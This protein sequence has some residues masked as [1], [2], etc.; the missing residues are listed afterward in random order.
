MKSPSLSLVLAPAK[1][2]S[3]RTFAP[4][5]HTKLGLVTWEDPVRLPGRGSNSI[6]G[7]PRGIGMRTGSVTSPCQQPRW[8]TPSG[9]SAHRELRNPHLTRVDS[10]WIRGRFPPSRLLAL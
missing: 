5:L 1:P 9:C 4:E 10:A 6:T 2:F 7:T 3:A 8:F